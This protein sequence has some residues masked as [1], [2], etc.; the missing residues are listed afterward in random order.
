MENTLQRLKRIVEEMG[1]KFELNSTWE[2]LGFDSLDTIDMVM[3]CEEEFSAE[4][5]DEDAEKI[6]TPQDAI[7]FINEKLGRS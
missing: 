4:I 7:N 1:L 2:Q 6:K 5:S 3:T